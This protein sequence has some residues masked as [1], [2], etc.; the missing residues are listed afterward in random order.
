MSRSFLQLLPLPALP[1]TDSTVTAAKAAPA[2]AVA[3][4]VA[5]SNSVSGQDAKKHFRLTLKVNPVL[6]PMRP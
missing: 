3:A 1:L 2:A 5:N 6:P 4:T